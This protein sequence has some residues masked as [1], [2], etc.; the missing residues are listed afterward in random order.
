MMWAAAWLS[1]AGG[2]GSGSDGGGSPPTPD[3]V[4][5]TWT[6]VELGG[7]PGEEVLVAGMRVPELRIGADGRVTGQ[8]G[9]NRLQGKMD[10]SALEAGTFAA[11]PFATTRMAGPPEAMDVE[12]LF[13]NALDRAERIELAGDRLRLL[14]KDEVLVVFARVAGPAG[15]DGNDGGEG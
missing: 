14:R 5:G 8:S 3:E 7:L 2:C 9:I 6:M 13:L 12:S 10:L 11:G 4:V 15:G 1:L